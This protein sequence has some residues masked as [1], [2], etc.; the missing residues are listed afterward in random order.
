MAWYGNELTI[1][2]KVGGSWVAYGT[3]TLVIGPNIRVRTSV[4]ESA[5]YSYGRT[6]RRRRNGVE[7]QHIFEIDLAK[8]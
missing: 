1:N 4:S 5:T 3:L 6:F 7:T 8:F 2:E